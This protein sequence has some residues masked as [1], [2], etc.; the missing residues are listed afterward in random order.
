[1][2]SQFSAPL[3]GGL[4][5]LDPSHCAHRGEAHHFHAGTTTLTAIRQPDQTT[6]CAGGQEPPSSQPQPRLHPQGIQEGRCYLDLFEI[7]AR[8]FC[9]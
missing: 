7:S 4:E 9:A 2:A 3:V 1:M 5:V 6:T 8:I